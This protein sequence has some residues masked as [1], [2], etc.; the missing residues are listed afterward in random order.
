MKN[1]MPFLEIMKLPMSVGNAVVEGGQ[2]GLKG[3]DPL[4]ATA[5]N[6]EQALKQP[7]GMLSMGG[8]PPQLAPVFEQIKVLSPAEVLKPFTKGGEIVGAPTEISK[9][10][11]VMTTIF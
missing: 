10:K 2:V 1:Q 6:I 3:G 4:L 8:Q 11:D 5:K 7:L 9:G